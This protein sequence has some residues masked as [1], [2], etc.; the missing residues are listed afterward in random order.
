MS[1]KVIILGSGAAPGIPII[2]YGWGDC[3]PHN[4][5]NRR[6]RAGVYV[7][8]HNTK[9]LIDTSA[10][11]R[12]QLLENDI[13]T[14]DGVLYTHA[15]A[16]HIMGIDDL[17]ALN[18]NTGDFFEGCDK[19]RNNVLN[20]Y[21]T[22]DHADELHRRFG[23]VFTDMPPKETTQ[24]PHLVSNIIEFFQSFYIGNIKVT[25]L[26][27][28]GHPVPTTGYALND[29]MLVL[30]P[31]YKVIPPQTLEYLQKIDVNVLIMPLTNIEPTM[32]HAGIKDDLDYIGKIRPDKVY[33]THLGPRCDYD[34]IMRLTPE[35]MAPAYDG[36]EIKL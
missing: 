4:P 28:T 3:N 8:Y 20:I 19:T 14:I 10:D 15:H 1:D 25:P 34:E 13:Q 27:F 26:S 32:Y 33:F 31:D 7:E 36:L 24:R 30:V 2:A 6:G 22:Q 9:I 16:D 21:A 11:I 12:N 17:R 18:Y 23:Y 5:K 35:N 29:G